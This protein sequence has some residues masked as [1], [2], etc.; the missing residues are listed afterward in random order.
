MKLHNTTS[1]CKNNY[2]DPELINLLEDNPKKF[3]E[4]FNMNNLKKDKL[5]TK[6]I[7]FLKSLI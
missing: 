1:V 2:L 7:E 6:Y 4:L 5:I 3:I